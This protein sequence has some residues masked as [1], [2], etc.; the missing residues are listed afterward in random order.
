MMLEW[1]DIVA[2]LIQTAFALV[3]LAIG[4]AGAAW[5]WRSY[6]RSGLSVRVFMG[7][8]VAL[9]GVQV[10]SGAVSGLLFQL[11]YNVFEA[12]R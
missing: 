10:C 3:G 6:S 8:V 1:N 5:A 2:I 11:V 12:W 4:F 7:A 9:I